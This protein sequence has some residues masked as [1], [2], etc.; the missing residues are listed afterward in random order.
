MVSCGVAARSDGTGLGVGRLLVPI[1][2]RTSSMPLRERLPELSVRKIRLSET[3][4]QPPHP[5]T[6]PP[7]PP[8]P[9]PDPYHPLP[10]PKKKREKNEIFIFTLGFLTGDE[11]AVRKWQR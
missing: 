4:L 2:V 10:P 8:P 1:P 11:A 9:P 7:P 5:H 6:P 3:I